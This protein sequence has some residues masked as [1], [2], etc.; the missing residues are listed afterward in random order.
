MKVFWPNRLAVFCAPN[1]FR[2]IPWVEGPSE[3]FF[4]LPEANSYG[5]KVAAL[6]MFHQFI[7]LMFLYARIYGIIY[8]EVVSWPA[9]RLLT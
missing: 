2:L 8:V 1:G 3:A 6:Q 5:S 7:S 4:V 9:L